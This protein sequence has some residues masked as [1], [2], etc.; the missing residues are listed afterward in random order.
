MMLMR[1]RWLDALHMNALVIALS[2]AFFCLMVRESWRECS[3]R[4]KTF[5]LTPLRGWLIV[6]VILGFWL[7]RNL[8]FHPFVWLA[9]YA[10]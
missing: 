7:L 3:G 1:G 4:G 6:G 9:P 5:A 2:V 8:P 10:L